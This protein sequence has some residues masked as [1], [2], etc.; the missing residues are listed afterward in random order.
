MTSIYR[1]VWCTVTDLEI[2]KK[3]A[4]SIVEMRQKGLCE[5]SASGFR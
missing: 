1:Q 2:A 4:Q 5:P 3:L